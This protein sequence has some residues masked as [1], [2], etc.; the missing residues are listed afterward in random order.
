MKDYLRI[1]SSGAMCGVSEEQSRSW[2]TALKDAFYSRTDA[3][4]F[5]DPWDYEGLSPSEYDPIY[6]MKTDIRFLR[7]SDLVIVETILNPLS[8]GTNME[9]AIA[10]DRGIP[11]IG[12]CDGSK[13]LHDWIYSVVDR[14]FD[15]NAAQQNGVD[16]YK[17]I[18]DYVLR[19]YKW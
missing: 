19:D 10:Y 18:V 8:V 6:S 13:Q 3:V 1:Y 15:I 2:R 4:K 11:I 7:Q 16:I 5:F 14:W 12:I 17:E 9:L